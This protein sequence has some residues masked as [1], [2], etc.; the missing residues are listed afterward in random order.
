MSPRQKRVVLALAVA[1]GLALSCSLALRG[2]L[3][4]RWWR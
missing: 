2:R 4:R 3:E 1:A